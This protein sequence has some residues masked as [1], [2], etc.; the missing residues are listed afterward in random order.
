M[1]AGMCGKQEVGS[2]ENHSRATRRGA[3]TKNRIA[4]EQPC[5]GWCA[6]PVACGASRQQLH[7]TGSLCEL[8]SHQERSP[9]RA[10]EFMWVPTTP[11]LAPRC[12]GC[13]GAGARHTQLSTACTPRA[14]GGLCSPPP[15]P[16]SWIWRFCAAWPRLWQGLLLLPEGLEKGWASLGIPRCHMTS[17]DVPARPQA[18]PPSLPHG[19]GKRRPTHGSH[20]LAGRLHPPPCH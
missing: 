4:V 11:T 17:L 9:G 19:D 1:L 15:R 10:V 7:T 13:A 6:G 2:A 18:Q 5:A 20:F 8:Q 12:R 16:V 14:L 3:H